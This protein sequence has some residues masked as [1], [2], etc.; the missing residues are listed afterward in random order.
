MAYRQHAADRYDFRLVDTKPISDPGGFESLILNLADPDSALRACAGMDTVLH[1]AADPRTSAEFYKDLLEPN[2][3]GVYNIFRAAKDQGCSRVIFA[4]SVNSVR[5]YPLERQVRS[6]DPPCPANIYGASKAFGEA[7]GAYFAA[8][9]ELSVISVRIGWF[10]KPGIWDQP[11][12]WAKAVFVSESDLC[13]L[14]D[15]CIETPG[16]RHAIVHGV[17]NN[18]PTWLDLTST[19]ELLGYEPQDDAFAW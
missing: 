7:L 10:G 13:Q 12:F 11:D 5:G 17:S 19:R 6:D 14:F 8:C 4:S 16:I 2:I 9:E 18:R 15:R 3:K 1:L